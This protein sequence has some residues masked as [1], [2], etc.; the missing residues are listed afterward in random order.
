ML[1]NALEIQGFK[2][3]P[4]KTK[5]SF[6]QG[7][8][9]VVGPNGSGKSNISDAI[10]W[11]MGETSSKQLRG[12]G[13]MEDVIF[14]GT[15]LRSAMGYASVNLYIDNTDRRIEVDNDEV[16]IGR[17]IY[18]S[19]ESEYSVN[20]Q[21]VRLKDVYELFLDTGL[22]KDGYS[23]IGQGRIAEIVGAKSGERREIFE[24]AAGIAKHRYRKKEAEHRL[25][26][27]EENL[28]R[29][30]DILSVLAERVG[31]LERDSK[32]AMQFLELSAQRKSYEITLWVDTV[33]KAKETV[34]EQQ[35]KI[36]IASADYDNHTNQIEEIDRE[37]ESVRGEIQNIIVDIENLNQ[38][39]R[40]LTG[41]LS[42]S[43]AQLAVLANDIERN[44]EAIATA[45]QEIE[46]AQAGEG[47]IT[48]E[49]E[50]E[51]SEIAHCEKQIT[52]I[53]TKISELDAL[54]TEIT[55][56][57][58]ATGERRGIIATRL[59]AIT[60]QQTNDKVKYASAQSGIEAATARLETAKLQAG[61]NAQSIN[62]LKEQKADTVA[63]M[64]KTNDT[65]T[66][67]GNIKNGLEMKLESRQ[68]LLETAQAEEQ[69]IAR[70]FEA[71]QQ[72]G[73]MLAEL[74]KN[75]DGYQGSVKTVIKA[76]RDRRLRGV[77]GPV[78]SI[79][80]VK[81]GY[82]TAVEI[83]LGFAM[84]NI[85]VENESAAKAGIAFLRQENAGR[86]TFLPLD[87]MKGTRVDKSKLLGSAIC[88]A[89]AV[90]CEDKYSSVVANLLG[91]III[92]DD[93]NEATNVAKS[94]DYRFRIVTVGGDVI[95]AGGSYT[96]GSVSKSAGLFSRKQEIDELRAQAAELTIKRE[97]A[98]EKA[99]AVKTEVTALAAEL[100]A[101]QSEEITAN[102]DKIRCEVELSRIESTLSQAAAALEILNAECD[103]LN[104]QIDENKLIMQ[105]AQAA[106]DAAGQEGE[107]LES[108]LS[109]I[110]GDDD[111]FMATRTR[112][113][114]ELSDY[115]LQR[116]ST[117]KDISLHKN[118][119]AA[120][121]AR[122]GE[123]GSRREQQ[124]ESVRRLE[125]A[126]EENARKMQET[127]DATQVTR[128]T[129]TMR[130][131]DIRTAS[132]KR[133][134]LEGTITGQTSKVR[135]ITDQ[136]EELSKEVARLTER[137]TAL[138]IEYD[139]TTAKLWEEYELTINDAQQFC[140][141][142]DSI[143]E[144][145]RL[146]GE[147]R[148]KIR[149]LGNVN[150]GAIEEYAEVSQK[151]EFLRTQVGDVEK[152]KAELEKMIAELC[153]EMTAIFSESFRHINEN[154][155]RIFRELF[156][157]GNATLSLSNEADM[158][159]SGIDIN[160]SPP[161]KVIKSLA[162]LSGG[163]QALV[164][165]SIYFAILAVNPAPFCVL[166]EIEAALDDVNVTRYAQYL[167]R[168]TAQTQF[169]VITHR[170]GTMEEADMLYGVTMQE[171]GVSALLK[172][173][174]NNVDATFV[175]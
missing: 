130:E 55:E 3:F 10:R 152:S 73:A 2:S 80:S 14:G 22:G 109:N 16:V 33:R 87:T 143:T 133:I 151:Y 150:V 5:V 34:R 71:K 121:S 1:L 153:M 21:N 45:M 123:A 113:S 158:L 46:S 174:M 97:A 148:N 156:G 126:N 117:E 77:I 78:S 50:K 39:I 131:V 108:E 165:I 175:K 30:H 134:T 18:R 58:A 7:I 63:M 20:G 105:T 169:I 27:A 72:R 25:A 104:K 118:N 60:T 31:P 48:G 136:R 129:I 66:R 90:T 29:L 47:G 79:V 68:R 26:S 122:I 82:E 159:E 15:Q 44:K 171:D 62:D 155:G 138:E 67:L 32:K 106:M 12:G 115:K 92:V 132:Q 100:T 127:S 101:T 164:A 23:I 149:N 168:I 161:G 162:L 81:K 98:A 28:V 9:A 124:L 110:S 91:R 6:N 102:G 99:A 120:L 4:D 17:K 116:L 53:E 75:L 69:T 13:K 61:E 8:T 84:Q 145:R 135:Q 83:A 93:M 112:L 111:G 170:R 35:R 173:D 24:E 160:V 140:V 51:T 38:E 144:L 107:K 103:T 96:G 70:S 41:A 88:A 89:D 172:L 52:E 37:T 167:R 54:L 74:E 36:E 166:D 142:F 85:V 42:G 119:I 94:L 11:V 57:S 125:L 64:D 19:G 65:L 43:D 59:S 76:S 86:A 147:I 146:V 95:N 128:Q 163:E 141:E 114:N 49:I 154:F 40:S 157:G 137:K 56:K 139:Q